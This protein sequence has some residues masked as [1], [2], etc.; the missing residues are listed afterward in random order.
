[1]TRRALVIGLFLLATL[2]WRCIQSYVSPY[3]SPATGY[4]VVDGYITANG[5]TTF[6]LTR[7]IGLPGDSTI[8]VVTGAQ[9]Q[10]EGSDNSV[11]PFTE[12]GSGYYLLSSI[13]MSTG[14]KYRLRIGKMNNE[15]Y[16]SDYIPYKPTPPIDSTVWTSDSAGVTIYTNT[17]DPTGNTR[18]YQWKYSETWELTAWERSNVVY[19]GDTLAPRTPEQQIYTCWKTDSSSD[20]LIGTS[21]QLSEDVINRMKINFFPINTGQLGIEY[22]IQVSQYAITDS[23]FKYLMLMKS[24]TEQLGSVM[25]PLPAQLIGNIHCLTHPAEVVIGYISAGTLQQQRIF[26]QRSQVPGWLYYFACP[27]KN[28]IVGPR[29]YYLY[30]DQLSFTP[31]GPVIANG[32]GGAYANYNDCIDCRAR[33]H[34]SNQ[35][36]AFWE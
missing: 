6:R 7:T 19:Q 33:D 27:F 23:G 8:P 9:L 35:Q 18:Y 22:S 13:S 17:H 36:P 20:I 24:N 16:L 30:F 3:S 1:V 29:D 12:T 34:A 10:V 32:S 4:L 31:I 14:V 25:D 2:Q 15:E 21:E 26:I 5:P 11:Y 28:I